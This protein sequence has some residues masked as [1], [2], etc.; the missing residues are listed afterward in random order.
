MDLTTELKRSSCFAPRILRRQVLDI[1]TNQLIHEEVP[2][3]SA[4]A[5]PFALA[6]QGISSQLLA[7]SI[8]HFHGALLFVDISGFTRLSQKMDVDNLR[9]FINAYFTK[10]IDIVS[11]YEGE[12]IK[13]AGD[14]MYII[15]QSKLYGHTTGKTK[16]IFW[17]LS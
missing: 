14:A 7:P 2:S 15:W 11:K 3:A 16:T 13:F 9:K 17:V 6:L 4:D 1:I 8:R 12:V 10:L 5:G